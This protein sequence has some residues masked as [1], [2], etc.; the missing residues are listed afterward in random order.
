MLV[1]S[2][3]AGVQ[4]EVALDQIM[5]VDLGGELL[6]SKSSRYLG[7]MN[8]G[9]NAGLLLVWSILVVLLA[10]DEFG[11]LSRMSIHVF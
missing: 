9:A 2:L 1:L 7:A 4:L 6:V 3:E 10:P 5:F 8:F 11:R